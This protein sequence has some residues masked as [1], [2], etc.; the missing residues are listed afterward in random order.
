MKR[1]MVLCVL[2]LATGLV[3]GEKPL[4]KDFIGV[5]GHTVQ[6]K[7]ELYRPVCE[8]VRDYHPMVWDVTATRNDTTFP[9]AENKVHWIKHVY[10]PWKEAG[11]DIDL[12]LMFGG[13]K[14]EQWQNK[15]ADSYKYGKAVAKFFGPSG[16]Q[17]ICSSIEIGN[18]P[19]KYSDQDYRIIFKNMAK[20][21]RTGDSK[22]KILTC[23]AEPGESTDY[24]KSLECFM[25][26]NDLYDVITLHTYAQAEG[27]PTWRRS[28][29]EDDSIDYLTRITDTINWRD[30]N[31]AGKGIWITEFGWDSCTSSAMAQRKKPFDKWMGVTDLEQ[32]RYLVRSLLVF[33]GID[34]E[35][36][37][38][39]FFNDDDKASVHAGAGLTRNFKPKMS[40]YAVSHLYHTLGEYRF[41]KV[42]RQ[43]KDCYIYQY[44]NNN[45]PT[46]K[47][48]AAWSPTGSDKYLDIELEIAG[49]V[50]KAQ[51]MP[52]DDGP[53]PVIELKKTEND[54]YS[55]EIS[56][57][58]VYIF[59]N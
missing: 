17:N 12:C 35:R 2:F 21:I 31:A 42:I 46:E 29:P 52:L 57:S 6:F 48:L 14:P 53:A 20:G 44:S 8:V 19:G 33:S 36:A 1:L 56:E 32:A 9:F 24:S 15:A 25:G 18:E 26:L 22:V 3:Y 28:Y 41:E 37:Y 39:Y 45:K 50:S 58:P 54:K 27:W 38:I 13:F 30:K 51:K 7:A 4:M 43:D 40:Y 34:V 55:L 23:A 59:V 5:N 11:F 10:G 16:K 49:K 47:I